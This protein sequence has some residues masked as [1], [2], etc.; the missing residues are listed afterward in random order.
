MLMTSA[1]P[2]PS[3]WPKQPNTQIAKTVA[4]HFFPLFVGYKPTVSVGLQAVCVVVHRAP[5]DPAA[6]GVRAGHVH[7]K[8][9]RL[10]KAAPELRV[11][12]V[13]E[14]HRLGPG[15]RIV[16]AVG[17]GGRS[18]RNAGSGK[19]RNG[20]LVE[21]SLRHIGERMGPRKRLACVAPQEGRQ[22]PASHRLVRAKGCCAGSVGDARLGHPPNRIG[23]EQSRRHVSKVRGRSRN[24]LA[25]QTP[26][27]GSQL[28]TGYRSR[29]AER[30][31]RR[32]HRDAGTACPIDGFGK[33]HTIG[34]VAVAKEGFSGRSSLTTT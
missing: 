19:P 33:E 12:A 27:E 22:L 9:P 16:R 4:L 32:T 29:G 13:Q 3:A 21:R 26:Q 28:R 34:Y 14:S 15:E 30:R 17:R 1:G 10:L 11:V 7:H 23:E 2:L 20:V 31:C 8:L 5:P 25:F 18:R 24:W 6:R